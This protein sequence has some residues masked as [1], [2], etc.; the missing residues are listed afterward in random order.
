MENREK[1]RGRDLVAPAQTVT[2]NGITYQLKW[3]NKQARITED[4][5]ADQMGRDVSYMEILQDL[6]KRKHRAMQ[7]CIYG[8]LIAGGAVM[9]WEEFDASFNYLAIDQLRDAVRQAV[10]DT[11]PDP[12]TSGN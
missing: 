5:Y 3:C 12:E 7:A 9:T 10:L 4:V 2:L 8:A 11:L 1:Q 6:E